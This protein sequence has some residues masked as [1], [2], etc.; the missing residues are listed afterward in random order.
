MNQISKEGKGMKTV[1]QEDDCTGCMACVELC[2]KKAIRIVDTLKSYNAVIDEEQCVYCGLCYRI[3]QNNRS[4]IDAIYPLLW[5]QGWALDNKIRVNSSSG[6]LAQAIELAFI[7]TGGVVCSCNFS[8]GIF[9][10]SFAQTEDEVSCFC[11]S[12]YVK[13]TPYGIYRKIKKEIQMGHKIL[14]VGLPCQVAAVKEYI[15]ETYAKELYT[16]DLICHGT[17]S[18]QILKIFLEQH[19]IDLNKIEDIQFRTKTK[20]H[21]KA[22][23]QYIGTK[24][25]LDRYTMAFLNAICYTE[26][27]YNCQFAKLER[28]SDI[29]LGD[30]WGSELPDEEQRKGISLI[31]CQTEKGMELIRNAEI[32]VLDV[33]LKT[34]I[35]HNQQLKSPSQKPIG[36]NEFFE[37]LS[38][39]EKFDSIIG[40]LYPKQCVKQFVKRIII[41]TKLWG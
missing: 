1:C 29:T 17:P 26:N 2:P 34:A 31:L 23:V 21:L 25:V 14:F 8:N 30:S 12:K 18:P 39:G 16:A 7:K 24:G 20:F 41:A 28:S 13:S 15:G 5:K 4:N 38:K 9:G 3:C 33:D 10:Y 37:G 40:R 6:G 11:G 35:E 27:C 32:E 19:G 22:N 36:R